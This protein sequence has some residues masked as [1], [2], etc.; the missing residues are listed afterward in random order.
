VAESGSAT[1]MCRCEPLLSNQSNRWD[2]LRQVRL[3]AQNADLHSA[4]ASTE[5]RGCFN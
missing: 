2:M 1:R 3:S 4:A 5:S